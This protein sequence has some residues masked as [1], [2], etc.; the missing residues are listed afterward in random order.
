MIRKVQSLLLPLLKAFTHIIH[1]DR[2]IAVA[3]FIRD[4]AHFQWLTT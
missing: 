2:T 1:E 3:K 4:T